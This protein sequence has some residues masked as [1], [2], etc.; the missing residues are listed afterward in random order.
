MMEFYTAEAKRLM[1]ASITR[2]PTHEIDLAFVVKERK[3]VPQSW[4][5]LALGRTPA[6][7]TSTFEHP[8]RVTTTFRLADEAAYTLI[9]EEVTFS[10]VEGLYGEGKSVIALRYYNGSLLIGEMPIPRPW[11]MVAFGP[12]DAIKLGTGRVELGVPRWT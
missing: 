9:L 2:G 5:D 4:W 10:M 8:L 11:P 7:T 1:L 12:N 3:E 6:F